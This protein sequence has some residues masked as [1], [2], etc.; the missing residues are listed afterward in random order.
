MEKQITEYSYVL[1]SRA[2]YICKLKISVAKVQVLIKMEKLWF[3]N[4]NEN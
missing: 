2:T 4:Y 3:K 1:D